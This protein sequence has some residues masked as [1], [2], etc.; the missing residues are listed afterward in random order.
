M[1]YGLAC[2]VS[3]LKLPISKKSVLVI[4]NN[5]P[6]SIANAINSLVINPK[7]RDKLSKNSIEEVKNRY[8]FDSI[9]KKH[10]LLFKEILGV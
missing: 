6:E 9:T 4:K 5:D 1:S 7:E 2:I 10:D 8:S 3:D